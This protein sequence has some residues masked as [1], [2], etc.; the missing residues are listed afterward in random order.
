MNLD[1]Y[2][3]KDYKI[4]DVLNIYNG[5][6]ITQEEIE[7]N[8]GTLTVVQSGE[9]NN[10]V[11]GYI[12][13]E[14]CKAMGYTYTT[15][16]C[17][18]VARSGSAGFVSYQPDGCVVGD[19]A[20]ILKLKAEERATEYIYLFIRTVLM[21]NKY[22]YTYGRK[23][24]ENKYMND[25]ISLPTKDNKPDW[26]FMERYICSLKHKKLSTNNKRFRAIDIS[27]WVEFR[28]GD[29]ISN[30]Y[31]GRALNKD[32]LLEV[33]E[34][35]RYIRYITRTAIDNGCELFA[36]LDNINDEF[37]ESG[38]AITIGDTTATCFYQDEPFITG[39][40]MVVVR[41]DWLNKY[42]GIYIVAILTNEQYKYSYGRAYLMDRIKDTIL[43]LPAK[44]IDDIL[45][46][47][48][49]YME[50]YIKSLPYGDRL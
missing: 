37:I 40:H 34:G 44:K 15:D 12:N 26:E 7:E 9:E 35:G 3:W 33:D 4:A 31:K 17:L 49:E 27:K 5:K 36:S 45:V 23:V 39:D 10:G 6:G 42:T 41:A 47:D 32:D 48:W 1:I 18:T 30:I 46:P 28:F 38:N 16:M 2:N 25:V 21:A 22:K 29:L 8:A 50:K 14:Y 19:S 24:T 43:K 11:L 20:K 13:L